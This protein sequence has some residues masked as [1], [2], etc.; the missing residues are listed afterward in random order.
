MENTDLKD[1]VLML[2]PKKSVVDLLRETM[3]DV[4]KLKY[5]IETLEKNV[6]LKLTKLVTQSSEFDFKRELNEEGYSVTTKV[7]PGRVVYDIGLSAG[8]ID[9]SLKNGEARFFW[10]LLKYL[11]SSKVTK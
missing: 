9:L 2:S 11:Y 1:F 5:I 3:A 4:L 8:L 7:H 6:L 10:S